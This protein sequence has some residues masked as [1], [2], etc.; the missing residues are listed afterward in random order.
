[1][2]ASVVP[3]FLMGLLGGAHCLTMCG[4]SSSALCARVR[5]LGIAYNVGRLLGYTA[6]GALAGSIGAV[7]M[8]GPLGAVRFGLRAMAALCM[9]AVGLHLVGLPSFVGRLEQLG[10]PLWRRL[11]PLVGRLVPLRSA[12]AAILVG[13][14]WAAMPCGLIYGALAVAAS[15]GS[16]AEGALTMAA[17][18][19][20]TLP[21]MLLVTTLAQRLVAVLGR[22]SVRRWAGVVVLALG[23]WN[24]VGILRQIETP[25]ACCHH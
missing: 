23:L 11:A 6:L 19:A 3:A 10:G 15:S 25:R 12:P 22:H 13:V 4:S 9:L 2:I 20:G 8:A 16:G 21:V 5:G 1:M 18:A 7:T 24:T 14:L 17:F